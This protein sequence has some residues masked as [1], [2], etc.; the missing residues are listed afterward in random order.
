MRNS[1]SVR[2]FDFTGGLNTA[3]PVTS[4]RE[5]QAVDLQNINLL[6][7]GGFEKRR[8]NTAFNSSAMES[9]AAIHGLGY[10]RQA[11]SDEFLVAVVGAKIYSSPMTGTM[12][13]RTGALSI[14]A[15]SN[16]IWTPFVMNDNIHFVGG[17][18][19]TPL[20]WTG[21]GNA[22]ALG[23]S[24]PAGN[25][26][27]THNRRAFI[28][29]TTANPSR[30]A[31]SILGDPTDWSGTGSGTQD[32]QEGD[33]DTLVCGV[34]LNTN[35]LILFKQNSMHDLTTSSSPFPTF[36]IARG[37]G[38]A[39]KLAWVVVN[40]VIYFITP[41]GRMK[42]YDGA[43][44]LDY[45][46]II[47]NTW[48]ALNMGR[49]QF[50]CGQHNKRTD[51][52]YWYCSNGSSSSNNYCIVWDVSKKAWLRHTSGHGMNVSANA[53]NGTIY[54]AAYDGKIYKMDVEATFTDASESSSAIN[55]Y[56]R[57]GWL[58]LE[59]MI[60]TKYF[61]YMDISFTTQSAGTLSL[62]YGFDFSPDRK[63]VSF[64]EQAGGGVYGT[65]VYGTDVYG[66]ASDSAKLI[67]TKG[68]GKFFQ[69]AIKNPN[70]SE[71]F[72]INGLEIPIK[73]GAPTSL[74]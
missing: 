29:N 65:A 61:P 51:Q 35:R 42:S 46:D 20:V 55:A 17:A 26:G 59:K 70:A 52:I 71:T 36:P 72:S 53:Q 40:G 12:T 13:D 7:T 2:F 30:I 41:Q 15:G 22:T 1:K 43:A 62:S 64:S 16:N 67:H 69:F 57:S 32:I 45:P 34:P 9:G 28:G 5:N 68:M 50:I 60:E 54:S 66:G 47:D 6:P 3:A 56:W 39:G 8:G 48:D 33:G 58:D 24:P 11:D 27:L 18:P 19:D 74:I 63:T 49:Y 73:V 21:S 14:T 37:V 38:C 10:Y 31:W 23:G 4:L 25:F 44:I